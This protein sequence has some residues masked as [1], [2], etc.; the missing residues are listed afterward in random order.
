MASAE[1]TF[2]P[3]TGRPCLQKNKNAVQN[4]QQAGTSKVEEIGS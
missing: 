4:G 1:R 2:G 3:L